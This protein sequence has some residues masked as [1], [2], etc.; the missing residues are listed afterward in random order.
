MTDPAS[1][2]I[3]IEGTGVFH[4]NIKPE[5]ILINTEK[6]NLID[7]ACSKLLKDTPYNY[8]PGTQK[9]F[10]PLWCQKNSTLDFLL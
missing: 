1:A 9:Y 6:V 7:F 5:N 3:M 8:Y 4:N 10:P 2:K